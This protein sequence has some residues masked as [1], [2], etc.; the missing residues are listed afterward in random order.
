MLER[1]FRPI[2]KKL[3]G[4]ME[5]MCQPGI[6]EQRRVRV[7]RRHIELRQCFGY[8]DYLVAPTSAQESQQPGK[9]GREISP[10]NIQRPVR[11]H[12]PAGNIL[13]HSWRRNWDD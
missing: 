10:A 9:A 7:E 4:A 8:L 3:A 5:E 1:S 13:Q 6:A 11:I 12:K 2:H